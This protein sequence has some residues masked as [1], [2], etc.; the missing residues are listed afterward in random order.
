MSVRPVPSVDTFCTI[1]SMLVSA[2]GDR[3]E[4]PRGDAGLVGHADDGDLRLA[5]VVRDAGDERLL[6]GKVL[7][8]SGDHGAGRVEYDERTWIGM[9]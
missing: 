3:L 2:R 6:H 4:D 9:S 5:A 1:M 8:R 7:H